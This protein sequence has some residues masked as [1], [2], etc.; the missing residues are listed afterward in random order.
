MHLVQNFT[1]CAIIHT[2]F[3]SYDSIDAEGEAGHICFIIND[4]DT[5]GH[6][7]LKLR[8]YETDHEPQKD[9]SIDLR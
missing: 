3:L 8:R 9:S 1:V 6:G 5:D 7:P 2:I 4:L